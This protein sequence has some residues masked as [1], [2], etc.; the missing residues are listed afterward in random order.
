MRW[1]LTAVL[2]ALPFHQTDVHAFLSRRLVPLLHSN[3]IQPLKG[4]GDDIEP[5]VGPVGSFG[6]MEGG[7]VV[8]K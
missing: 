7:I 4:V 1:E 6:D 2:L 5:Y 3:H 8:G